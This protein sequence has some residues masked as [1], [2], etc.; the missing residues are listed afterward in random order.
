[1]AQAVGAIGPASEIRI[2]QPH[3]RVRWIVPAMVA[4]V[5]A[6]AVIVLVYPIVPVEER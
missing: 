5:L 3:Y 2:V 4:T 6:L 1:M